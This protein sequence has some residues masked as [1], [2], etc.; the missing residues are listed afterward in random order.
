[1]MV[2]GSIVQGLVK[3]KGDNWFMVIIG[4]RL[5]VNGSWL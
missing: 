3:V 5:M 4:S 2:Q 1:M